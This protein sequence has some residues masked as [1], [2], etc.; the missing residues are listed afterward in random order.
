MAVEKKKLIILGDSAFAEIAYE[1]FTHDSE[2]D[3]MGFSVEQ[4][5]LKK[6]TLFNLP[7]VAFEEIEQHFPPEEHFFFTAITYTNLNHLRTRL[8]LEAKYKGYLPASY[9]SS[10]AFIWS[11]VQMGEHCFIFEN[12]VV[13]PFVTL[14]NNVVLWSGNHIGHHSKLG[15]NCFVASHAVISGFVSVDKNCFIGVNATISNNITIAQDC[16]IGAGALAVKDVKKG[17]IIRGMQ[18]ATMGNTHLPPDEKNYK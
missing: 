7:I 17:T 11:N 6:E 4:A 8:Y 13:Q 2:Y 1:Y 14:G 3:V 12:N 9:V 16:V 15:D 10:Q 5:F 18:G